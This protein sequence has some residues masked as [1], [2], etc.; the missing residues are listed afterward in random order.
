MMKL[1]CFV[2]GRQTAIGYPSD[3]SDLFTIQ[4]F[5]PPPPPP[6][7]IKNPKTLAPWALN[8]TI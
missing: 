4:L 7:Q 3:S 2:Y 8:S 6:L 1:K 5:L